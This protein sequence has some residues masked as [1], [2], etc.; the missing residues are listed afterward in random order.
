[1]EAEEITKDYIN[2]IAKDSSKYAIE[3]ENGRFYWLKD[4]FK[5]EANQ[6]TD[7]LRQITLN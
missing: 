5:N 6:E 7:A 4:K 1:M 2:E 3:I